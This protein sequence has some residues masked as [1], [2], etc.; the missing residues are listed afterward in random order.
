MKKIFLSFAICLGIAASVSAQEEIVPVDKNKAKGTSS[1]TFTSMNGHEVLPQ[2]GEYCLGIGAAGITQYV[3]DIFGLQ[4]SNS[5]SPFQY[6]S[7]GFPQTVIY[8]K[9]MASSETAYRG[10]ININSNTT[11]QTDI[12]DDDASQN[13]DDI[14]VD[15][16]TV[17]STAITI[18]A[19]LE[20]RRGSSRV[21][22]V[23]GAEAFI[24]YST[25]THH[26]YEYAN[27][28]VESNQSPQS[29]AYTP[30]GITLPAPALGERIVKAKTGAS[31][32]FGV[33]AFVGVEYFIA[34][35]I[36]LG[37]EFNWGVALQNFGPQEVTYEAWESASS[38]VVHHTISSKNGG[39]FNINTGNV[40]GMVNLL[41]YF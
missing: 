12:I 30:A 25:G 15:M 6:V 8:G 29:T 10:S 2:P 40:G 14:L 20:K 31:Q 35:K 16:Y 32:A 38:K 23:Y 1:L 9:Y 39:S 37:G 17:Q 41:F 21:Q 4:T 28:I 3:G 34:P 19:G 22:G 13:P 11:S 36:S 26:T 24:Y 18:G 27:E 5:V 33:R 7:K